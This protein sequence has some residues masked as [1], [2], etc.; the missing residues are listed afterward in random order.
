M[1]WSGYPDY[2]Y[3]TGLIESM[4]SRAAPENT[5]SQ[6]VENDEP[7]GPAGCAQRLVL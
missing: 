1:E 5:P 3:Y 4:C 7:C 2:Q 6:I